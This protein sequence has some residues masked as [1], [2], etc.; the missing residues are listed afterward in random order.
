MTNVSLVARE[1]CRK[2]PIVTDKTNPALAAIGQRLAAAVRAAGGNAVVSQK[3]GIS[4][5]SLSRYIAAEAEVPLLTAHALAGAV[6]RSLNWLLHGEDDDVS[7]S[8]EPVESRVTA[9]IPLLNVIASAGNG[10]QNDHVEVI[11]QVTFDAALLKQ[12]RVKPGQAHFIFARGDSMEPTIVDGAIVLI[13]T[14]VRRVSDDGIYAITMDDD[15]RLKRVQK[16]ALGS[17]ELISDNPL[18]PVETLAPDQVER[19]RVAGKVFWSG[20]G[21]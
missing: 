3:V 8:R 10:T 13:D 2:W 18:Y 7:V 1:K 21:I 11:R 12:L 14:S 15:V 5:R 6:G 9:T 4:T 20:S 17:V 16:R 19:L